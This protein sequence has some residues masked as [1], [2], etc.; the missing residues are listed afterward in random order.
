MSET[1]VLERISVGAA[2]RIAHDMRGPL[3]VIHGALREIDLA[4]HSDPVRDTA[5]YLEMARRGA[6]KLERLAGAL[7]VVAHLDGPLVLGNVDLS[8]IVER[9]VALVRASERAKELRV[10]FPPTTVRVRVAA[11]VFEHALEEVIAWCTRRA[12]TSVEITVDE[13]ARV[14]VF[15]DGVAALPASEIPFDDALG[16]ARHLLSA[17]GAELHAMVEANGAAILVQPAVPGQAA[18]ADAAAAERDRGMP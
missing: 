18:R 6:K 15:A 1:K 16:L 11:P 12:K 8:P 7:D 13:S 3:E 5:T 10:T 17:Q 4:T 9:A 2:R 14:R